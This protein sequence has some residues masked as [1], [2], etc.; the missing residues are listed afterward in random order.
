MTLVS[1]VQPLN[2]P[3]EIVF[4]ASP[5]VTVDNAVQPLKTGEVYCLPIRVQ[6]SALNSTLVRPVQP[7]NAEP[8]MLVTLL[9]I[10]TLVRPVQ[11]LNAELPIV[12]TPLG[13]SIFVSPVQPRNA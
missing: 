11:P 7:L 6:L 10:T 2:A 13:I 1:P 9:G 12:V 3:F 8:P 4:T 5:I